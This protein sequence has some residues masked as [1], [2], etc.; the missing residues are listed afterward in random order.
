[1]NAS[2]STATGAPIV[3]RR[4]VTSIALQNAIARAQD[5]AKKGVIEAMPLAVVAFE[6]FMDSTRN[7]YP[8]TLSAS[9][10]D[11]PAAMH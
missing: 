10:I 8:S 9:C 5:V 11:R 2:E 1:M 7:R 4:L 3:L 6:L